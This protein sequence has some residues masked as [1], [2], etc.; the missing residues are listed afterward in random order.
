MRALNIY[1]NRV[2]QGCT[3]NGNNPCIRHALEDLNWEPII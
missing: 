3:W 2:G 1:D